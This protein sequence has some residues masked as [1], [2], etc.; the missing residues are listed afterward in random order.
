MDVVLL[1][2]TV[3][4]LTAAG[5]FGAVTWYVLRDA[6]ERSRARV[7]SLAAAIDG[8]GDDFSS[9]APLVAAGVGVVNNDGYCAQEGATRSDAGARSRPVAELF[10]SGRAAVPGRPLI[11]VAIGAAMAVLLIV[12]IAMSGDIQDGAD[13]AVPAV[14]ASTAAAPSLELLA[15]RHEQ[16]AGTLTVTGLVRNPGSAPA[17]AITAVV[18]AFDRDGHFLAS[19]RAPLE[20][21]RLD[22]GEESPFRVTIANVT[23]VGR[24]RVTFR[25]PTAVVRHIDRRAEPS[26]VAS[27]A[28]H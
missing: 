21:G 15:M 11:K 6:R 17:D 3:F 16:S 2:L 10:N 1:T 5:G 20:I 8:S 25:T 19:G 9:P 23:D 7:A 13:R 14:T 27:L 28:R 22:A 4:S 24:Y 18:F 26:Q 12:A